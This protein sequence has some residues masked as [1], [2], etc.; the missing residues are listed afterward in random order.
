MTRR[1]E[2]SASAVLGTLLAVVPFAASGAAAL[3]GDGVSGKPPAAAPLAD[4]SLGELLEQLGY[5]PARVQDGVYDIAFS[6]GGWDWIVRVSLR[7][8]GRVQLIASLLTLP[9]GQ[10]LPA[11]VLTRLMEANASLAPTSF[12][13][14]GRTI[15]ACRVFEND[16][17]NAAKLRRELDRFCSDIL[18]HAAALPAPAPQS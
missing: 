17:V 3:A 8:D 16:D 2:R 15:V 11:D 1:L 18:A 7:N 5:Q 12:S 6:S 13:L 9:A 10:D 14:S 4:A